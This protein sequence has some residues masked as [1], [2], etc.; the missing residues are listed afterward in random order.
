MDFARAWPG[1]MASAM[2]P[3]EFNHGFES[4]MEEVLQL[5]VIL[6]RESRPERQK[7]LALC[8]V[9][10][11]FHNG[12]LVL[13]VRASIVVQVCHCGAS[14]AALPKACSERIEASNVFVYKVT[15]CGLQD[16]AERAP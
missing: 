5:R 2:A 3:H 14:V 13:D 10:L 6:L 15:K 12:L 7:V 11:H 9:G 16:G 4:W 8:M 1:R